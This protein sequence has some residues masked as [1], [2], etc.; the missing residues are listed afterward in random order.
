MDG[1]IA[2]VI[3]DHVRDHMLDP[4]AS[5]DDPRVRAAEDLIAVVHAYLT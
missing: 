1:F 2:E 5:K 3:E 4:S